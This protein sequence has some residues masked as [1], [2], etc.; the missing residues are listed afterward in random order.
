MSARATL[1]D[2]VVDNRT[3]LFR[4]QKFFEVCAR[5]WLKAS[6]WLQGISTTLATAIGLQGFQLLM[7]FITVGDRGWSVCWRVAGI[8]SA[9][10]LRTSRSRWLWI[11]LGLAFS[12]VWTGFKVHASLGSTAVSTAANLV[13]VS[14][15]AWCLPAFTGV[16]DWIRRPHITRRFIFFALILAPLAGTMTAAGYFARQNHCSFLHSAIFWW[17][18]D[19]L[20]MALWLPMTLVA[21]TLDLYVLFRWENLPKTLG[22]LC[23]LGGVSGYMFFAKPE[24]FAFVILP[25]LVWIALRL[26][27]AGSVLAANIL[28]LIAT[29]GA[30]TGDGP[31]VLVSTDP[32]LQIRGLQIFL[33]MATL[34]GMPISVVLLE[35]EAYATK[36]QE[37]YRSMELQA[38]RDALTGVANRRRFDEMI[39]QEWHRAMREKAPLALLMV[40]ADRFK[41]YNDCYGHQAGDEALR[42]LADV[43]LREVRRSIDLVARY[44]GEEFSILLPLTDEAGAIILAERL[45]CAIQSEKIV[46]RRSKTGAMT[47]SIGCWSVVPSADADPSM[48]IREADAA[49]YVAKRKGRNCVEYGSKT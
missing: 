49:L 47:V 1:A 37:A 7:T 16:Q 41:A 27:F 15:A 33:M 35:R 20:G 25:I 44:G 28:A 21:T 23:L 3:P 14:I 30:L 17:V 38:T 46:H 18:G 6:I 12:Q 48:L 40:D 8:T 34:M 11:L 5:R 13:E 26:G 24:P 31:F 4:I 42:R 29:A 39:Q 10:M 22:L 36:L 9:C 32:D 19:S 2:V 45:R 43:M